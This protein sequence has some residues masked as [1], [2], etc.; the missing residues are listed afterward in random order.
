[1]TIAHLGIHS[2]WGE[3]FDVASTKLANENRIIYGELQNRD[4]A[5]TYNHIFGPISV[6]CNLRKS[7]PTY[8]EIQWNLLFLLYEFHN[9]QRTFNMYSTLGLSRI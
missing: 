6:H 9:V 8:H 5:R 4:I 7:V 2:P 3:A 1:M